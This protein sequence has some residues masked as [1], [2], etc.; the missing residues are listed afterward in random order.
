MWISCPFTGGFRPPLRFRHRTDDR[1]W[2][3]A[4]YVEFIGI[5][6][7][8][9]NCNA[10]NQ[11]VSQSMQIYVDVPCMFNLCIHYNWLHHAM[12]LGRIQAMF[13]YCLRNI[14]TYSWLKQRRNLLSFIMYLIVLWISYEISPVVLWQINNIVNQGF[15]LFE[16]SCFNN[17]KK[18]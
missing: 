17:E 1:F 9:Q 5:R 3:L 6:T 11:T 16:Y 15:E 13:W 18:Q 10:D 8:W 12:Q 4:T 14:V 2:N 7:C